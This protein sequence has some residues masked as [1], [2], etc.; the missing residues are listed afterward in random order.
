MS[1][2]HLGVVGTSVSVGVPF[3]PEGTHPSLHMS[4]HP[5]ASWPLSCAGIGMKLPQHPW[6]AL[7][8]R[9]MTPLHLLQLTDFCS[10][11]ELKSFPLPYTHSWSTDL[12]SVMSQLGVS[13]GDTVGP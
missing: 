9:L 1:H 5:Q 4:L 10:L 13:G 7:F 8:V 2:E 3:L 6:S 11:Q 12:S